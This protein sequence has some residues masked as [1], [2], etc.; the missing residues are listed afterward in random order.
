M[1]ENNYAKYQNASYDVVLPVVLKYIRKMHGVNIS[2][3]KT[4]FCIEWRTARR[5]VN[6]LRDLG[7]IYLKDNRNWF[8]VATY[9]VTEEI[10][11]IQYVA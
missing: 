5:Y 7:L 11:V 2:H 10:E 4:A 8:P 6:V 9:E 3:I 1:I